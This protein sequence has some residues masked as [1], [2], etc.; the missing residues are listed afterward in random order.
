MP[1][2]HALPEGPHSPLLS[3]QQAIMLQLNLLPA[4]YRYA[5]TS[6]SKRLQCSIHMARG[7]SIQHS[8]AI[9]P[10]CRR[11]YRCELRSAVASLCLGTIVLQR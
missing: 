8:H 10:R 4:W 7:L 2:F 5:I 6:T 9:V 1:P 11:A 3:C